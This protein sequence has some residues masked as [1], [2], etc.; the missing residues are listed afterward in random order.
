MSNHN[1]LERKCLWEA[2]NT[3]KEKKQFLFGLKRNLIYFGAIIASIAGL[4]YFNHQAGKFKVSNN[5][6]DVRP[7]HVEPLEDGRKL[8]INLPRYDEDPCTLDPIK[9]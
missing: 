2:I 1:Q 9:Q 5:Y 3:P 8:R 4:S 6:G 7:V